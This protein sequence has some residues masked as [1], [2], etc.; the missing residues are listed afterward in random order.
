MPLIQHF[1][2]LF[3]YFFVT[4]W[5][6]GFWRVFVWLTIRSLIFFV[7][8]ELICQ[9][10]CCCAWAEIWGCMLL[11]WSPICNF[12]VAL[13]LKQM[14]GMC[15]LIS[16]FF[17]IVV[18]IYCYVVSIDVAN[19]NY[20][21]AYKER[22]QQNLAKQKP[23]KIGFPPNPTPTPHQASSVSPSIP[24]DSCPWCWIL[25]ACSLSA[26]PPYYFVLAG[27]HACRLALPPECECVCVCV[28]MHEGKWGFLMWPL[29]C[30]C[31]PQLADPKLIMGT[32]ISAD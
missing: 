5:R 24:H 19:L 23:C 21:D 7:G 31:I 28:C 30:V 4:R 8:T 27:L 32:N 20:A 1:Q 9:V 10:C 13:N 16:F 17:S 11:K 26:L 2:L 29:A 15:N 18:L 6:W 12:F 14:K 25:F 22:F 3:I